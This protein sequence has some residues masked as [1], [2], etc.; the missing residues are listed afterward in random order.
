LIYFFISLIQFY[1]RYPDI[2]SDGYKYLCEIS[3]LKAPCIIYSLGSANNYLFEED[4][5]AH[6]PC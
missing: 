4:M 2:E 3:Q 6:T 5:L 1:N